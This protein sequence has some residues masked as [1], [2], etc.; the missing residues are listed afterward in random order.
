MRINKTLW[1]TSE[2]YRN[3]TK[4]L[5]GEVG[6]DDDTPDEILIAEYDKQLIQSFADHDDDDDDGKPSLNLKF[7]WED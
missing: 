5:N 2:V 3:I 1:E 6:I 7:Y 4:L